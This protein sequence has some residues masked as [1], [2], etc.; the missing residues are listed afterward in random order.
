MPTTMEMTIWKTF[1]TIPTTAIGICENSGWT[2]N[3]S[4]TVV[5]RIMLLMAAMA[6]TSE[7]WLRKLVMPMVSMRRS[8]A[9]LRR[10][11]R[12][13]NLMAFKWHKYQV[14]RTAVK[15]CPSTV[16]MA[17]PAI[18]MRKPKMKIGSKM[19]LKTAPATVQAMANF[20][21]PSPRMI[22]FIACPNMYSGMPTMIQ[23][24]YS[25][26]KWNSSAL[27]LPPKAVINWSRNRANRMVITRLAA[28]TRTMALPTPACASS[29]LP[30]PSC[31]LTKVQHPSPIMTATASMTTV[32]GKT[33]VLAA[34]PFEPR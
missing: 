30:E 31:R 26:A 32:N 25:W 13:S 28:T 33:T 4:L 15:S 5:I 14:D 3:G 17:A 23:E 22:A 12:L 10:K 9:G 2:K 27:T 34:F 11:L 8:R 7:I 6:A 24:K 16:A 29:L 1:M 19:M 20:G 18:P 21:E